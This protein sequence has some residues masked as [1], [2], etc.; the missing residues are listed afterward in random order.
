[1]SVDIEPMVIEDYD[2]VLALWKSAETIGLSPSD[3][4]EGLERY[5]DRNP[6]IS[7]VAREDGGIV[8]AILCGNDG[9]RGYLT[10]LVVVS[11]C[12]RRRIGRALVDRC[13]ALLQREGIIGCNLFILKSNTAGRQFWESI[14]WTWPDYWGVMGRRFDEE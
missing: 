10:H 9:R 12:R 11:P 1:M 6:G 14:G 3:S 13:V 7:Q 2:E 4:R 5:L 8:G